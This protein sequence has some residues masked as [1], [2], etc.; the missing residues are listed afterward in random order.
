MA[1]TDWIRIALEAAGWTAS[2]LV[3]VVVGAWRGGRRSAGKEQ[4]IKDDYNSKIDALREEMRQSMATYEKQ[5]DSRNDLLVSQFK[6]SFEGIRRQIDEHRLAAEVRY[7]PR[8]DFREFREEYREDMR[9]VKALVRNGH[10]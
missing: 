7:L 10:K 1:E 9:E 4:K 3:G 5:A 6:E 2:S 8:D